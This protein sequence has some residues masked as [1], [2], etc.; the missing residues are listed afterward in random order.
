MESA[1]PILYGVSDFVLMRTKGAYYLDRTAYIRELENTRYVMFLRPRRFGK[2]LLVSMLQCYYDVHYAARFDELFGGL[3]IHDDPTPEHGKYLILELNFSGVD[4]RTDQVQE[5]FDLHCR[6]KIDKFV[7][8]YA[9]RLPAG[10]AEKVLTAG[11]CHAKLNT[12]VTQLKGSDVRFMVLID[13]YDNFTNT[14][15][16]ENGVEAYNTLCHG[17]GFFKQFFNELKL[18]TTGSDAPVTRLFITGVT[19]VTLDDVTSGFNIATN[20]SMRRSFAD[21]LG[22]THADLRAML[23]HYRE[24]AGFSFDEEAVYHTLVAWYDHYRFSADADAAGRVAPEVCNTTLVLSYMQYLLQEKQVPGELV[25]KNMRT[26]YTKIRYLVTVNRRI[27]GNYHRL[28][29]IIAEKGCTAR[30]E[31]SFQARELTKGDNF[32]SLLFYFGLLA[33]RD[34]DFDGCRLVVPNLTVQ[35]FINDFIP[36]AY[37]DVYGIDS[38]VYDI[39]RGLGEFARYGRWEKAIDAVSKSVDEYFKVRDAIEG[40]RVVQT[41]MCSLLK[42]AHGP[43]IVDHEIE[44][45]RG[46]ADISLAPQLAR[47]PDIAWAM[48]IELKYLKKEDD[49][50][51]AA[52][53]AIR[54]EAVAQLDRYEADPGLA[55][56]WGLES[57]GGHVKL[58]RLV[59]V[60]QGGDRVLCEAV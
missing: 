14:I 43:Y 45:R 41:A 30:I 54:E 28:E 51:P 32:V 20:L 22:F 25:D 11:N 21:F 6:L 12:L 33:I 17:E 59:I 37:D 2:S 23:A 39:A 36:R 60:F 13:E 35:E 49:A 1:K 40:E 7:T 56:A 15:L 4:K 19:P 52:L 29:E 26:D 53:A 24:T 34:S 3:A 48:L 57:S 9:A 44:A 38:R 18:A 46:F 10:T 55:H 42:V 47:Y 31:D 5:S 50:S 16:A 27:N 8:D 58:V